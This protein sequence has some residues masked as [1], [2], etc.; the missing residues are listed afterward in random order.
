LFLVSCYK[1]CEDAALVAT[2]IYKI[3]ALLFVGLSYMRV[4]S[5]GQNYT[6]RLK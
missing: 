5:D 4:I 3:G 6:L 2:I 1:E